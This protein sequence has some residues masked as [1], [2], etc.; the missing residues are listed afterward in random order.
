[1]E[2]APDV[3]VPVRDAIE[4]LGLYVPQQ[5]VPD[6]AQVVY[7]RML[8]GDCMHCESTLGENSTCVVASVGVAMV[9]CSQACMQDFFQMTWV[10]EL[11]DDL[12]DAAK[13][14]NSVSKGQAHD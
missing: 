14:R 12:V 1:M 4:N 9:F 5:G 8:A 13:A 7:E 10:Q 2:L 11:Y 3:P 6:E